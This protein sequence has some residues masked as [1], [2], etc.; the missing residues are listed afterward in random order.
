MGIGVGK[1]LQVGL[2]YLGWPTEGYVLPGRTAKPQAC[3]DHLDWSMERQDCLNVL[4]AVSFGNHGVSRWIRMMCFVHLY[5]KK[6]G[7]LEY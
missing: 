2:N 4:Q 3:L 6:R 7:D 5:K 1:P